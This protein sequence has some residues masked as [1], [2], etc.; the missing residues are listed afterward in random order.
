M[1]RLAVLVPC[2]CGGVWS[3]VYGVVWNV[4]CAVSSMEIVVSGAVSLEWE[5]CVLSEVLSVSIVCDVDVLL[6]WVVWS[7]E[8]GVVRAEFAVMS[9]ELSGVCGVRRVVTGDCGMFRVLSVKNAWGGVHGIWLGYC[10]VWSVSE[11]WLRGCV[12]CGAYIC[13]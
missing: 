8:V 13:V 10:Q 9:A 11:E 4:E 5:V 12:V 6:V 2:W 7:V 3:V 1:C